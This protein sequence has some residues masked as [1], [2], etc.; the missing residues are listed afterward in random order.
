MK[1]SKLIKDCHSMAYEK[2]FW[3]DR[4]RRIALLLIHTE[5]SEA[6]EEL[7]INDQMAYYEEL[8][9]IAIRLFDLMGYEENIAPTSF[10]QLIINKMEKNSK[11]PKK[12]GKLF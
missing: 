2:G 4:D 9:D 11:R 1:I 10:E 12:H 7:R 6:V 3:E 5:V 8:A